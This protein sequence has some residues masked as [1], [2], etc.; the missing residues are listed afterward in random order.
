MAPTHRTAAI[1]W[2]F[3]LFLGFSAAQEPQMDVTYFD[4]L[5]TRLFFEDTT[6]SC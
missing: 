5:P 4:N 6:V 1:P 2:A 3:I